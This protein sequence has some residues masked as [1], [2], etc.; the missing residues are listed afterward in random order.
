MPNGPQLE[1]ETNVDSAKSDQKIGD[2]RTTV[3]LLMKSL[4]IE[5]KR[6]SDKKRCLEEKEKLQTEIEV[7][8]QRVAHIDK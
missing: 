5:K 6:Q 4:S 7:K 2:A 1:L 3:Q 8:R